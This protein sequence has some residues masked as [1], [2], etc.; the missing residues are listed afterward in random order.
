MQ[1]PLPFQPWQGDS[2]P[3]AGQSQQPL[4][5]QTRQVSKPAASRQMTSNRP[6]MPGSDPT[7]YFQWLVHVPHQVR[8]AAKWKES[9]S[10]PVPERAVVLLYFGPQDQHSLEVAIHGEAPGITPSLVPTVRWLR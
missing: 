7:P 4:Q 1:Q 2:V 10:F 8:Q 5:D 6:F 9:F 3:K